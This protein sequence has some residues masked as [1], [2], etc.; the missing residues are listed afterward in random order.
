MIKAVIFD[1]D[2]TFYD[3]NHA[4]EEAGRAVEGYVLEQFGMP[5]EDYRKAMREQLRETA[6]RLGPVSATHNRLIRMQ[7]VLEKHGLPVYP[8][9]LSMAELYWEVFLRDIELFPGARELLA[10]LK[11]NGIRIG[12]GTNMTAYVQHLKLRILRIGEFMD[13]IV[14]SEDAGIEKPERGFFEYCVTKAGCEPGEC[15]FVGDNLDFDVKAPRDFGMQAVLYG[16]GGILY[17]DCLKED[18]RIVMGDVIIGG[19]SS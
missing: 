2:G 5:P 16:E 8:H 9:T 13:F 3:Y 10:A 12:L 19:K 18:G 14:T 17:P 6:E 11:Q 7:N 4:N 15:L 1:L